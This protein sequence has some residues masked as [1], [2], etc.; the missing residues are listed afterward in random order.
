MGGAFKSAELDP[1]AVLWEA[2]PRPC[3]WADANR[4]QSQRWSGER[5]LLLA[6]LDDARRVP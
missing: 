2:N 1:L 3:Q 5:R 4:S 6:L